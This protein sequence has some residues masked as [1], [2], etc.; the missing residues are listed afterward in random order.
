MTGKVRSVMKK[1]FLFLFLL[2]CLVHAQYEP[3]GTGTWM[4][5]PDGYKWAVGFDNGLRQFYQQYQVDSIAARKQNLITT[6]TNSQYFDGIFGLHTFPTNLN[7]FT[8]GPGYISTISGITA[9]G[10]L[11]GT[12]PNPT[13]AKFN[14]QLPSYYLSYSNL[15]GKPTIYTFT[16][17]TS[18]YTDGTGAYQTFPTNLSAFTNGP[19]YATVS[20]I[21]VNRSAANFGLTATLADV[22]HLPNPLVGDQTVEVGG[23]LN[24]LSVTGTDSVTVK[25]TWTDNH[26]VSKTKIFPAI[27]VRAGS[28]IGVVDDYPLSNMSFR[29]LN[30]TQP[31][32]SAVVTGTGTILYE[33]MG[34]VK[35]IKGDGGL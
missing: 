32:I 3:S 35:T 13:A 1:V 29:A 18:Q 8:N 27:G 26:S 4:N 20:Q 5:T 22:A 31:Q 21:L 28:Q 9:G 14:G 30:G 11:S 24:L 10:D 34:W 33:V 25:V 23:C 7:A 2:P 16:G 19:N 6:G 15:T 17:N 12:Y